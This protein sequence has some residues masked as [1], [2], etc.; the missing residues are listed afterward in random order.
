MTYNPKTAIKI[1]G[2]FFIVF[3]S[4]ITLSAQ[5][6]YIV[7]LDHEEIDQ[8]RKRRASD[9]DFS[10]LCDSILEEGEKALKATPVPLDVIHYEGLLNTNSLRIK[11]TN[12][13]AHSMAIP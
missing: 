12:S 3:V 2:G 5:N 11:T 8:L 9:D 4:T 7:I 6:T 10:I 13:P 1:I